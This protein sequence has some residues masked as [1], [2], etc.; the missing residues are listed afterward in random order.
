MPTTATSSGWSTPSPAASS[1]PRTTPSRPGRTSQVLP[2]GRVAS[3][4]R[5][6]ESWI[7]DG[8][9]ACPPV[10]TDY[11]SLAALPSG[12]GLACFPRVPITVQARLF[13]CNCDVDYTG[14]LSPGWVAWGPPFLADPAQTDPRAD[15][16]DN[17]GLVLD[18]AGPY[19]A[20][21]PIGEYSGDTEWSQPEVVEVTGIFDH[22][23]AASCTLTEWGAEPVPTQDCRLKFAVMR[24]AIVPQ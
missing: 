14:S 11:R 5:D 7:A 15:P 4:S 13:G 16:T 22:P 19:P 6:G 21:L 3:A 17:V 2:L 12:V 1:S 23:A 8:D 20:V 18:P 10:P 9:F 24:L